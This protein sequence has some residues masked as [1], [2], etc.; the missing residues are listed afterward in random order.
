MR[1]GLLLLSTVLLALALVPA[2]AA[3]RPMRVII[4]APDDR[5]IT[6]QCAFSVLGHIEGSEIDTTFFDRAGNPVK[7]LGVFPGN[8]LTLTNLD[9]GRS[10]TVGA[11]GSFQLR[12]ERDGSGSAMVTGQ[13]AWPDGNPITGEPGIWYQ[14]GRVSATFDAEGNT[15]SINSTGILVDLCAELAS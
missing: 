3:N 2:A 7:L 13:G 8:A 6:D 12:V 11:T 5:V 15:T 1:R 14:S 9:T 4:P 10:I